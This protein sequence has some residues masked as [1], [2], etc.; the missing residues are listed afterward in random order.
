MRAALG[1][2]YGAM[3]S[4]PIDT[5]DIRRWAMAVYWPQAPPRLYWDD[6]YA[7]RTRFVGIVAPEEFNPFAWMTAGQSGPR[8]TSPRHDM[9][10]TEHRIGIEGPGLGHQLNGGAEV[11]YGERMRPGDVIRSST[12]LA[13]YYERTGRLGLMLFTVMSSKWTNQRDELVKIQRNTLIRY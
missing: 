2:E 6:E 13:D 10:E 8:Q 7:K 11:E 9:D 4:Y 1:R 5:S 12:R 3:T